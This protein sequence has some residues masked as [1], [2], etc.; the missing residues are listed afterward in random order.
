MKIA[1][2]VVD[3][4]HNKTKVAGGLNFVGYLCIYDSSTND[5]V[6]IKASELAPSMGDLLPALEQRAI[7][8]IITEKIHPMALKILVSKG[9]QVFQSASSELSENIRRFHGNDLPLYDN[10]T[11]M[12]F[13]KVCGT[14]CDSCKADC[15]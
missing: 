14:D 5:S 15:N 12:N 9:F 11:S 4:L 2:P 13:A 8:V 6:W 7:S 1:I 10:S 3:N